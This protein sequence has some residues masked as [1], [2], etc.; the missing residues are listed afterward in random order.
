MLQLIEIKLKYKKI[1]INSQLLSEVHFMQLEE[2]I[3]VAKI[4]M[5]KVNYKRK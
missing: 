1:K 2:Y 5:K 3:I 4:V